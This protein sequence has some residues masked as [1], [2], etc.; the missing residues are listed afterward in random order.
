MKY[1]LYEKQDAIAL[2]TV[3]RPEKLNV[4]NKQT[5]I[6]IHDAL[7]CAH[8]DTDVLCVVF[9]AAGEKAFSA[10][11][12]IDDEK[13]LSAYEGYE[14]AMIGQSITRLIRNHRVPVIGAVFGYDLG[15]GMEFTLACDFVIA[16][17]DVKMGL[18]SVKLGL[19]NSFGGTQLL[20]RIVGL[21]KAKEIMFTGRYVEADEGS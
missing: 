20:P 21:Q 9:T 10:G 19:V 14:F 17:N 8:T 12:D 3:N 1:V 6:E 5:L 18:P 4:Y 13:E 2:I 11:G 7:Q 16:S 15:G